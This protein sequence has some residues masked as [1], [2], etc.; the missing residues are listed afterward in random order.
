MSDETPAAQIMESRGSQSFRSQELTALLKMTEGPKEVER[1]TLDLGSG[2]D[3]TVREFKPRIG[4]CAGSV[5]PAWDSLSPSL[6]LSL[7]P[8]QLSLSQNK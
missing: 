2:R 7:C 8:S 1:P 6:S 4:L 5:E 3:L